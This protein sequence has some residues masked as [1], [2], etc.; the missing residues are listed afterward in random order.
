MLCDWQLVKPRVQIAAIDSKQYYDFPVDRFV[1]PSQ[2]QR[3]YSL[4]YC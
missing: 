2:Q 3:S 1:N 4:P